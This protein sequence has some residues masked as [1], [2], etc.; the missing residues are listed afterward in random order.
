MGDFVDLETSRH[1]T[2]VASDDTREAFRA[3]LEKREPRFSGR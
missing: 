2:I 1:L 3:F